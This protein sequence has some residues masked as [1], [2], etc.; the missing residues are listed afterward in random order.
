[1][2][3]QGTQQKTR[4]LR[5]CHKMTRCFT[6]TIPLS[7][8]TLCLR[9]PSGAPSGSVRVSLGVSG[10]R[11]DPGAPVYLAQKITFLLSFLCQQAKRK[12]NRCSD[13]LIS[14]SQGCQVPLKNAKKSC[15]FKAKASKKELLRNF[16]YHF[17]SEY[18][19]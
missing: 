10:S 15:P 8:L 9:Q 16:V 6:G 3:N 4:Y 7:E 19:K 17:D 11:I 18:Y 13:Q 1:M 2:D 5:Q 12:K 14:G